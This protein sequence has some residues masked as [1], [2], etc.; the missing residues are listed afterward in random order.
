MMGEEESQ[1][2]P[3]LSKKAYRLLK[4]DMLQEANAIFEQILSVEE[5]NCYALVGLGDTERK[6]RKYTDAVA[7]YNRCLATDPEN[8]Y[9]LFGLADCYKS[10]NMHNEAIKLWEQYLEYDPENITVLTRIADAYR[11]TRDFQKSKTMYTHVLDKDPNN[12][13]ALIG[14]GHLHYNFKSFHDALFYWTKVLENNKGTVDIRVFTSI[15]N[16]YRKIKAF[17]EGIDYFNRSLVVDPENVH[18]LLGIADCYRGIGDQK[19]SLSYWQRVLEKDPQNKAVLTRMG[20]AYCALG[21]YT[22]AADVYNQALDVDFDVYAFIGLANI[23]KAQGELDEAIST[24]TRIIRTESKNA[25]LYCD[26]ADC[27]LRLQQPQSAI[28]VLTEFQQYERRNHMINSFLRHIRKGDIAGA[29]PA[30]S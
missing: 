28:D 29:K 20:D 21:D 22:S 9:A 30:M 23:S 13:Y 25:R 4:K 3:E 18:A 16:C 12:I 17:Q 8:N 5:N 7:H 26:L 1:E 2:I 6:A 15:G 27:Y 10:L 24:L 19:T 14:M 11:K